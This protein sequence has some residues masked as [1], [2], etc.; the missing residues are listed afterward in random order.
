LDG[1]VFDSCARSG[2]LSMCRKFEVM[3]D[4]LHGD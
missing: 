3:R 2:A 1:G 4:I